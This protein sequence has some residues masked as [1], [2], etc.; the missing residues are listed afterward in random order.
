[1]SD[2]RIKS[3]SAPN[4]SLDPSLDYLGSKI[5][6]KFNGSCLKQ[7]KITFSHGKTVNIYIVYEK[8]IEHWKTV[9]VQLNY[10][11]MLILMNANILDMVLDLI[12]KEPF[13]YAMDLVET[14]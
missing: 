10:Q 12:E 8:F 9:L 7:G 4:N 2:E 1:M 13:Q 6:V 14:L 3:P 11:K 5:R